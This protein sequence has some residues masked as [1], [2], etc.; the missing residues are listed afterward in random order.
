MKAITSWSGGKDSAY[1]TYKAIQE[2]F[3]IQNLL[4]MMQDQGK[5]NFHMISRELLDAQAEALQIPIIKWNTTPETY[6]QQFKKALLDAKANGAQAIITGDIF[7]VAQHEPAWLERIC[8]EVGIKPIKPLWQQDTKQLLQEFINQ[9]FK[10]TV[11]RVK[12]AKLGM[13]Y[14]G[15]TLNQQFY[16]DLLKLGNVDL[17]GEFG[18]YHTFV[19][20]GPI[21]KKQI[22]IQQTKTSAIN[23]WGRLEIIRFQLKPKNGNPK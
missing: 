22:E 1:A 17:C 6:E 10:A 11:V 19:T 16:N 8:N 23:G 7:D 21:F 9:V 5:S 12:T 13:E 4:I 2:G 3:E 15:R 18:E 20:D 14:L